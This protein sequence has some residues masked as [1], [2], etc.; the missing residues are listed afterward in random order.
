MVLSKPNGLRILT[1]P[2]FLWCSSEFVLLNKNQ[3][4]FPTKCCKI[5]IYIRW[6]QASNVHC[7]APPEEAQHC[8]GGKDDEKVTFTE[9]TWSAGSG[10]PSFGGYS[11]KKAEWALPEVPVPAT[12]SQQWRD[13][14]TLSLLTVSLAKYLCY[15]PFMP[16][17]LRAPRISSVKDIA[18]ETLGRQQAEGWTS[19]P[20]SATQCFLQASI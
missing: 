1:S 2:S 14:G 3:K 16:G 6:R 11:P 20:K 8:S 9:V 19:T 18:S 17:L 15:V 4:Y 5:K 12:I 13:K 7:W 10:R